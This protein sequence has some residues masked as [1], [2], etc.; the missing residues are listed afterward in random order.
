MN[1]Q[2]N[3][4]IMKKKISMPLLLDRKKSKETYYRERPLGIFQK[5]PLEKGS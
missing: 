4:N 5:N 3:N 2:Y 1:R